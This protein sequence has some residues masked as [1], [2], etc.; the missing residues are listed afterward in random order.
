MYQDAA[1]FYKDMTNK[2]WNYDKKA[3]GEQTNCDVSILCETEN[4]KSEN[5]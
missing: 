3:K 5:V 2:N 1:K 4:E